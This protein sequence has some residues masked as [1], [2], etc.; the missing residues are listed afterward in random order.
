M[1]VSLS[2]SDVVMEKQ[3]ESIESP[4]DNVSFS[5]VHSDLHGSDVAMAL[6]K[7][8]WFF[9]AAVESN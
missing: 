8:V 5:V 4:Y 9:K 6:E 7:S 3:S 2:S 1:V